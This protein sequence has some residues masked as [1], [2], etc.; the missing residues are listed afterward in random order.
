MVPKWFGRLSPVTPSVIR[1]AAD[2]SSLVQKIVTKTATPRTIALQIRLQNCY[3]AILPKLI[4]YTFSCS[5]SLI[6]TKTW[7]R[8][9]RWLKN[10][11]N[12]REQGNSLFSHI[13]YY[14]IVSSVFWR[15]LLFFTHLRYLYPYCTL[16][17]RISYQI[18]RYRLLFNH[19]VL[20]VSLPPAVRIMASQYREKIVRNLP[21]WCV[22]LARLQ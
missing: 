17:Q 11:F 8:I 21:F 1:S 18:L 4:H 12:H 16:G 22:H 20:I 3:S 19:E 14:T 13:K 5:I 6:F 9:L 2:D 15:T 10:N 7:R